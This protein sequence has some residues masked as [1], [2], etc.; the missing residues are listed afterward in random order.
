MQMRVNIKTLLYLGFYLLLML[1]GKFGYAISKPDS[2]DVIIRSFSDD[3]LNEYRS[4]KQFQYNKT[5]PTWEF[6]TNRWIKDLLSW[7]GD[8]VLRYV[9][10]EMVLVILLALLLVITV[11]QVSNVSFGLL[12]HKKD[13]QI[14]V[15][16]SAGAENLQSA[17]ILAL[18]QKACS[19]S[20][21]R[22][23]IRYQFLLLLHGMGQAG[24]IT[25]SEDK[26]NH[27]YLTE[28]KN[29]EYRKIFERLADVF[30]YVWYGEFEPDKKLYESLSEGFTGFERAIGL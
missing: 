1:P 10:L 9:S 15:S 8:H 16:Y 7:F 21:F 17:D 22:L 2:S 3:H 6:A 27:E 12:F 24:I 23:A 5:H 14:P 20:D 18:I 13:K 25:L 11:L 30:E 4:L 28:I 19:G 26:T 29:A